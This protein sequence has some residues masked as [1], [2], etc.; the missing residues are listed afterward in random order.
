MN[1][2]EESESDLQGHGKMNSLLEQEEERV[3]GLKRSQRQ[4]QKTDKKCKLRTIGSD[5]KIDSSER[6]GKGD[7]Q[8]GGE[9]RESAIDR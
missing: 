4:G 3:R 2:S 6:S 9:G 1:H 7:N 8:V 5:S